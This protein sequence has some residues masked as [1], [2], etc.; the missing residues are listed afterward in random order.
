[1]KKKKTHILL[2][3]PR[4]ITMQI[5]LANQPYSRSSAILSAAK[6]SQ[7]SDRASTR[8]EFADAVV[9]Y[10]AYNKLV[11]STAQSRIYTNTNIAS[12]I[13]EVIGLGS[14]CEQSISRRKSFFIVVWENPCKI[15]NKHQGRCVSLLIIKGTK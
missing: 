3:P 10:A 5:F 1:M 13:I 8:S 9:W 2:Q 7:S 6:S 15:E 14:M 11:F 4:V 12:R